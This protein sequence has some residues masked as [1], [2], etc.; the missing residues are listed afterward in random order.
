[1]FGVD[2]E[3]A[4][5][6]LPLEVIGDVIQILQE[7]RLE[8]STLNRVYVQEGTERLISDGIMKSSSLKSLELE[9]TSQLKLTKVWNL[10][11]E[12]FSLE[13]IKMKSQRDDPCDFF[14]LEAC[15][16]ETIL[17]ITAIRISTECLKDIQH[18]KSHLFGNK[19]K[20]LI[21]DGEE[22]GSSPIL[23]DDY[24]LL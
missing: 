14:S 1:L 22:Q 6:S 19:V 9:L 5:T 13:R 11:K 16:T 3:I 20:E 10:L 15:R 7:N 18:F 23:P 8:A 17:E 4:R 2:L 21:L 12:H 24:E